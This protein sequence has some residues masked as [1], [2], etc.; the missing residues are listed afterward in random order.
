MD[1][2]FKNINARDVSGTYLDTYIQIKTR[3]DDDYYPAQLINVNQEIGECVLSFKRFNEDVFIVGKDDPKVKYKFQWPELGMVNVRDHVCFVKR[4]AQR[5]WKK[6]LRLSNLATTV[7]D[8]TILEELSFTSERYRASSFNSEDIQ[9]LYSPKYTPYMQAI[10]S[11][12]SGSSVARAISSNFCIS[13]RFGVM[14]PLLYYK[15]HAVGIVKDNS[16]SIVPEVSHIIPILK[17]VVPNGF[18]NSITVA[19]QR[20]STL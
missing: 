19:A 8:S 16:I 7:F 20:S 14:T 10:E 18:H 2:P 17:R 15:K 5:Q 6:G 4:I 11:V 3:D 12:S 9:L 1:N 13:N